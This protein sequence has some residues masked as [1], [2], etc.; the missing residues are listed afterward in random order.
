MGA[1]VYEKVLDLAKR[2]GF[3]YPAYE[4]YGAS[5]GFYD[6]GPLGAQLKARL[7]D[8]FRRI[9]V[10][11]E[12][13][14]EINTPAI[15]IEP[16][17]KASGHVD[18]F[19]DVVLSCKKCGSGFRA[20]HYLPE[21]LGRIRS[22]IEGSK[23]ASGTQEQ[24]LKH[25]DAAVL[26]IKEHP[27]ASN[28]E[29]IRRM[30]VYED[31]VGTVVVTRASESPAFVAK[32]FEE[33]AK[34]P[35]CSHPAFEPAANFNLMFK[36]HVGPGTSKV[37]YLRPETAQAMF[38]DFPHLYRFFREK[39]PFAACQIGRAYRN[40]IAP[41]QGLIRLREFNQMEVEA[42]FDPGPDPERDAK[43]MTHASWKRAKG[44]TLILVPNTTG[45]PVTKT[46]ADAV[47]EKLVYNP[48]LAYHLTL[49]QRLLTVAGLDPKRL[50]FRQHLKDE[51]AHY[52]RDCW[53][54]EYE[55]ARFGWVECVGVAYRTDY[56]LSQHAKHS[57]KDLVAVRRFETPVSRERTRVVPVSSKLG[58]LFKKDAP[59]VAQALQALDEA[60][61]ASARDATSVDVVVDELTVT[62]P[63][64]AY[65]VKRET[66]TIHGDAFVPHVIEPSY[67][68][69]RILYGILEHNL[70]ESVKEGEPYT[71][72]RMP[73][74]M[75]PVTVGVFP[76]MSKDG[77]DTMAA[78]IAEK[79]KGEGFTVTYDDAGAIGR[80]YARADE[81]GTPFCVTVDYDSLKDRTVTLRDRDTTKQ[82][83]VKAASL[84][85][86]IRNRLARGPSPS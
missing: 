6:F 74:S 33:R 67:G 43:K 16:V 80:R 75:A 42:F 12:G 77:L 86:E 28:A 19:S 78:K 47:K 1:D 63:R 14:A 81:I 71:V 31:E 69:D 35:N 9:Y 48:A 34:C 29:A 39:L 85:R 32:G 52:A 56:D 59:K 44:A 64:E 72:L 49:V 36:T 60:R 13:A 3:L 40:E 46:A 50:R 30:H 4:L 22:R 41:R 17:L 58:P 73:P 20:D 5:A 68:V 8:I 2:R 10:V 82:E 55:S 18:H 38:V 61:A 70:L 23:L 37:A 54:A 7:E 45:K 21:E 25:L 76:L 26:E 53:D 62:V 57:G 51:M 15:T 79:L 24:F 83:R 84:A 11:E 65:D 66:E 27:T